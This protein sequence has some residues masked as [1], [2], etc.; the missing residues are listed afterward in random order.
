MSNQLLKQSSKGYE[1]IFPKTYLDAIKDRNS[2]MSLLDIIRSFN[3]YFLSYVGD[4]GNTRIQVPKILRKE[5]L[6]ITYV[7]YEHN[8]IT[9]WYNSNKVSDKE[10]AEDSNWR[11]GSNMLVG[12][13]SISSDGYWVINNEKT[14]ALARGEQGVAPLMRLSDDFL[15]QVSYNEGKHWDDLG[16]VTNYLRIQKYIGPDEA[17]PTKG[18]AEGTIYMKGPYYDESD[19]LN[20]NPT[21]RMW[22]YAW[23][24]NTLAWQDNG[25]FQS[26]PAGIVQ[27]TGNNENVVMSQKAV[28]ENLNVINDNTG[29]SE[30]PA[31]DVAV[32]YAVGDVVVYDGLLK[33]F[34]A[35]HTAGEW[36]GTDVESWSLGRVESAVVGDS[37]FINVGNRKKGYYYN[38]NSLNLVENADSYYYDPIVTD[39][40]MGDKIVIILKGQQAVSGRLMALRG[41][42]RIYEGK[43]SYINYNGDSVYVLENKL[44]NSPELLISHGVSTSVVAVFVRKM[45][46][47][48]ILQ[49]TIAVTSGKT[50]SKG[51][52]IF[53]QNGSRFSVGIKSD[54]GIFNNDLLGSISVLHKDQS[55]RYLKQAFNAIDYEESFIADN[56]IIGIKISL[57]DANVIGNGDVRLVVSINSGYTAKEEE[58]LFAKKEASIKNGLLLNNAL[59]TPVDIGDKLEGYYY[60]NPGLIKTANDN[61]CYYEP[62][63][64][65]SYGKVFIVIEDFNVNVSARAIAIRYRESKD[66]MILSEHL[67]TY[68]N[69]NIAVYE[70]DATDNCTLYISALQSATSIKCFFIKNEDSYKNRIGGEETLST[71]ADSEFWLSIPFIAKKGETISVEII[72]G[73]LAVNQRLFNFYID[74]K[75]AVPEA[76]F[77]KTG[78]QTITLQ[79][80]VEKSVSIVRSASGITDNE[81]ITLKCKIVTAAGEERKIYYVSADGDDNNDGSKNNPMATINSCLSNGAKEILVAGGVYLQT[82][83]LALAKEKNISI[84]KITNNEKVLFK[85]PNCIIANG[86]ELYS[87]K[88]YKIS[89]PDFTFNSAN[90]WLY[91]DGVNDEST[92]ILDEE[93]HPCQRGQIYRCDS[94]MIKLCS[95]TDVESAIAEIESSSEFKWYYDSNTNIIYFS[96][97]NA[98]SEK[99]PLC[100]PAGDFLAGMTND[101]SIEFVAIDVEYMS[102]N[103]RGLGHSILYDCSAKY[104]CGGGAFAWDNSIAE[105]I[106]CEAA[107]C[108]SGNTG[109]GFNGH[110]NKTG[111]A[112]AKTCVCSLTDCWSHDNND[113][114]YS[115]HERGEMVIR[116]G[117]FEYNGKGGVTPSYG[118]HCCCYN[119]YSR[120]NYAGFNY[121]GPTAEDEGGVGGQMICY[122]CVSENNRRGGIL[123]GFSVAG[124][125]NKMILIGC[126]AINEKLGFSVYEDNEGRLIDCKAYA[127]DSVRGGS[128]IFEIVNSEKVE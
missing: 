4:R 91:Q 29:I 98:I 57:S 6:W 128:G 58:D 88:V 108:A 14:E 93:R 96:S 114:G 110:A 35:E 69:E 113:D 20:D 83:N 51:F 49:E 44:F 38:A 40:K 37:T 54:N 32:D 10:W 41:S 55:S 106:R 62:I 101:I 65:N 76:L 60:S 72:G 15:F 92:L 45:E 66:D 9:E 13:I 30:Y 33:R 18:I 124:G 5:G 100:Y 39:L 8:V 78:T 26:I 122:N 123:R 27:E 117:L 17:L 115:D 116:G 77:V 16:K 63:K 70:L 67:P 81:D 112:F 97:P 126:I 84:R 89:N 48:S 102:F 2:G 99:N 28:T 75:T 43:P 79:Q 68:K 53:I 47:S 87:G 95:A 80:D 125:G 85:H 34:V 3:M 23:K 22:I 73:E 24:G 12:D 104:V 109:D 111:D 46:N 64:L 50:I 25:E 19:T 103:L 121:V 59:L 82:I 56:D 94:T 127:C 118:S 7:D 120:R 11:Q 90:K 105:F 1:N 86:S 61:S 52:P 42:E 74:N 31:F 107:R 71:K 36:I 21:Y 119:V